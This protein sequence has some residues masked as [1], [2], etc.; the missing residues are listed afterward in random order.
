M[1]RARLNAKLEQRERELR[2]ANDQRDV[3]EHH[4]DNAKKEV[5]ERLFHILIFSGLLFIESQFK[6]FIKK[7]YLYYT[8]L[9]IHVNKNDL[10]FGRV[11]YLESF[12]WILHDKIKITLYANS[13]QF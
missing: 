4:H 6:D 5:K 7:K 8:Y 9:L 13:W 2:T 3:L 12:E 1:E 10:N 11:I